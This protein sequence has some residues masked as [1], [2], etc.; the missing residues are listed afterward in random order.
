MPL[1]QQQDHSQLALNEW[2]RGMESFA[3]N[4]GRYMQATRA[5]N[6]EAHFQNYVHILQVEE[7]VDEIFMAVGCL[8]AGVTAIVCLL[9]L[10]ILLL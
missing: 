7:K 8:A 10:G 9:I 4:F 1:Q 2:A 6:L 3:Q 5:E